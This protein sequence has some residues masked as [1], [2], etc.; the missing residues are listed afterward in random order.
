MFKRCVRGKSPK[1]FF[2]TLQYIDFIV[3]NGI[4]GG[5]RTPGTQIMMDEYHNYILLNNDL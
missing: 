3:I 5:T 2:D 4:G 1:D